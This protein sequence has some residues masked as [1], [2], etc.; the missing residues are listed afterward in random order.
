M[1]S[2]ALRYVLAVYDSGNL[3]VAAERVNITQ[4]AF[5]KAI[6][7][8]ETDMG[9]KLFDRR[10]NGVVPTRYGDILVRHAR[11]MESESRHALA[12][13]DA[14]GGGA[15]SVLKIG[16]GPVWYSHLLP[17]VLGPFLTDHPQAR[18]RVHS[19][20]ISTLVPAL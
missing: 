19:G 17:Q 18:I 4:P 6:Q 1:Q 10:P 20:V 3:S 7:A 15:E 13:S 9:V 2:R 16:A 5:S 14:A 11:R 12:E 8:L